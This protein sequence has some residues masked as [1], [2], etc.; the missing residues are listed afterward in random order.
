MPNKIPENIE[1]L[2]NK[3]EITQALA[4]AEKHFTSGDGFLYQAWSAQK[5]SLGL[6]DDKILSPHWI[7]FTLAL[8]Q[9]SSCNKLDSYCLSTVP[10]RIMSE[11]FYHRYEEINQNKTMLL[12]FLKH[13]HGN[14]K[15]IASIELLHELIQALFL[16]YD[17]KLF[18]NLRNPAHLSQETQIPSFSTISSDINDILNIISG[19]SP[20]ESKH[21]EHIMMQ[22]M[23]G[24]GMIR[25]TDANTAA[26]YVFAAVRHFKSASYE[27]LP[28]VLDADKFSTYLKSVA[29][30]PYPVHE[31]FV[32]IDPHW[33]AGEIEINAD[34][35]VNIFIL[36]STGYLEEHDLIRI[37]FHEIFKD[38]PVHL[39]FANEMRQFTNLGCSVFALDDVRH[40][41]TLDNYSAEGKTLFEQ[42]N[43]RITQSDTIAEHVIR[44]HCRLPVSLMRTMQSRRVFE[45]IEPEQDLPI[46]KYKLTAEQSIRESFIESQ[47]GGVIQNKRLDM[48]LNK[49]AIKVSQF[50]IDCLKQEPINGY[51]TLTSLAEEHTLGAFQLRVKNIV[52]NNTPTSG[53]HGFSDS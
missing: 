29:E 16:S 38:K 14:T 13:F 18:K 35:N 40:F 10:L 5:I 4:L 46:N 11:Q 24:F 41:Y 39:F 27:F 19:C 28:T 21:L 25:N 23:N 17:A 37:K 7:D 15:N 45:A 49:M 12:A 3:G 8:S 33:R 1:H 30:L 31:R 2:I 34:G 9:L 43:T 44:H 52:A 48:K 20:E 32:L 47:A 6:L 42:L 26:T 50:I 51:D 22:L 36:N 53:K